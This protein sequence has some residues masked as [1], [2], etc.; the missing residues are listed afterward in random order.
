[1]HGLVIVA[2]LRN[3]TRKHLLFKAMQ[4]SSSP[5]WRHGMQ[6]REFQQKYLPMLKENDAWQPHLSAHPYALFLG[7]TKAAEFSSGALKLRLKRILQAEYRLKGSPVPQKI[8]LEELV[9]SLTK[10]LPRQRTGILWQAKHLDR[11]EKEGV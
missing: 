3:Y 5:Q 11:K 7:F 2:S 10:G 8:V 9:F 1:M 4:L 6:L